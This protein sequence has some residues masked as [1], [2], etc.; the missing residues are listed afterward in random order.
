[1]KKDDKRNKMIKPLLL[2]V[3]MLC[4][5]FGAVTMCSNKSDQ[6]IKL[7]NWDFNQPYRMN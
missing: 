6:K 1:M 2:G 3:G 7:P 5:A 4:I